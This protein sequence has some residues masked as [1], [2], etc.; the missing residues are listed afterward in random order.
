[1]HRLAPAEPV[2]RLEPLE[3]RCVAISRRLAIVAVAGMLVLSLL[4]II[5]ITLRYF[6]SAPLQGLDEATQLIMA[7]I[8]SASLPAGIATR[9]HVTIDFFRNFIGPR[10]QAV[11]AVIGG[12]LVLLLMMLLTW[13]F[14]AYAQRLMLRDD[15][16]MIIGI[17]TAPFWWGVT[18]MLA[19]CVPIQIIVLLNL[20]QTAWQRL[21][22]QDKGTS[23]SATLTV[24]LGLTATAAMFF[25]TIQYGARMSAGALAAITF[26][27]MWIPIGL[28]VP[29]GIIMA[30]SGII[31]ATVLTNFEA[32]T[33]TLAIHSANFLSSLS[34]VVLPLFLMKGSFATA[35]GLS[36]DAYRLAHA[37]FGRRRGGLAMATIGSCAGFGAVTGSSLATAAT[38]GAVALPEMRKRGYSAQLATGCV[39]AGGTLG[40]LIPPSGIMV[41]YAV[42]TETSIA[43]IFVAAV[44]PAVLAAALYIATIAIYVRLWPKSAGP[45]EHVAAREVLASILNSWGVILLFGSVIGGIY[46][47]VFTANEAGAVGAGGA[48][49]FALARGRLNGEAFW[50]VMGDVAKNTAMI[51]LLLFGAVAFSFFIGVTQLPSILVAFIQSIDLAPMMVIVILL[52]VYVL[53]GFVMDPLT[54]LFVTVPVIAPLVVSLGFDPVWWGVVTIVVVEIGLIHP[55]FGLNAFI[56]KGVAGDEVSIGTIFRGIVPFLISDFAK[57]ALLTAFPIITLWL[58]STMK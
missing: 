32:T 45:V 12:A 5:D 13:R 24:I 1:M 39:A 20:L 23:L 42:L 37:L 40:S 17:P 22:D 51:Y 31:G 43:R 30:F 7:V 33:N 15:A 56:I 49:L 25:V 34:L 19:L 54:T 2:S 57:L 4:T 6:L 14:G 29:V 26:V 53:L 35:A 52:A 28:M 38:I 11:M 44:I 16:T 46:A 50:R 55:P 48:F 36:T 41:I 3:Q 10:W 9:N 8:I 58:P 47:G 18:G 27:A 21:Q